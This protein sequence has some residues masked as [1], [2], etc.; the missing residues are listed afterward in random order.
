MVDTCVKHSFELATDVCRSCRNSYCAECLVYS[1]GPKK[2][3]YC[4][5]CA[6]AAAGIRR[7][8]ATPKAQPAYR[9]GFLGRRHPIEVVPVREPSFDDVQID[10][11]ANLMG[12]TI[13]M[14]T[15]RRR[16][17]AEL[18]DAVAAAESTGR[19]RSDDMSDSQ[20]QT[21]GVATTTTSSSSESSLA[22]W[23]AS[24]SEVSDEAPSPGISAWPEDMSSGDGTSF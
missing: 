11:P 8:G 19:F 18:V 14:T 15:T 1:H 23:A 7:T 21:A 5:T 9:R 17:S 16:V 2:P 24:L 3:P 20:P 12:S 4:V 6:L 10:L 13:S 22:D